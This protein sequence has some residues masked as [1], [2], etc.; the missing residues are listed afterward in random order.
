MNI[1]A[2]S[3][4]H[5]NTDIIK[6][7]LEEV[8]EN[9]YDAI[10]FAG[11]FT[12]FHNIQV[13]YQEIMDLLSTLNAPIFYVFGNRD[14]PRPNPT[15]PTLLK[16]GL[17]PEIGAGI[18]ITTDTR[19]VDNRTIYVAHKHRVFQENAFLHIE[20]HV[21]IGVQYHNYIN[22]GFVYR[23]TLHGARPLQGCYWDI[24]IRN[25]EA[26]IHWQTLGGM[27]QS[28]CEQHDYISLYVPINWSD[29]PFCYNERTEQRWTN[30]LKIRPS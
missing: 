23:D 4:I 19:L 22:L 25:R 15:R 18:F 8:K 3:D 13:L 1:L 28:T 29:C 10:I 7:L 6:K 2:F 26:F 21:H 27:Y 12:S 20:G 30:F 11:D 24:S 14:S 16:T 9:R 5:G 17:K